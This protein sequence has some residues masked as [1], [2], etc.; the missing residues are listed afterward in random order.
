MW[1]TTR[2][3]TIR[4]GRGRTGVANTQSAPVL[5]RQMLQASQRT[6]THLLAVPPEAAGLV[7]RQA[8]VLSRTQLG[9][10]GFT[11][12]QVRWAVR[13]GRWQ[14]FGRRV[15]VLSNGP[16][17]REQREW[18]AVLMLGKPTALAG[19]SAATAAGLRG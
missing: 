5:P 12:S 1:T 18:V 17:T 13:D 19:L 11:P 3:S 7:A 16:L 8:G 4:H 14:I 2:L 10:L 6:G 9:I 15:V